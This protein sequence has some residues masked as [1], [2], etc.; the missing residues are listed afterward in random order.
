MTDPAATDDI[1]YQ[2]PPLCP[3]H[4]LESA[5]WPQAIWEIS[6]RPR[7]ATGKRRKQWA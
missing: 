6:R 5:P 2:S 7:M 4:P 3:P 1:L